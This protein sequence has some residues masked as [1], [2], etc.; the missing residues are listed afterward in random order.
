MASLALVLSTASACHLLAGTSCSSDADCVAPEL[1]ALDDVREHALEP[2]RRGDGADRARVEREPDV[3]VDEGVVL[4]AG[5]A[6]ERI[7]RTDAGLLARLEARAHDRDVRA[8]E[9][10]EATAD[11]LAGAT[12]AADHGGVERGAGIGF[13]AD[14]DPV[15]SARVG[16]LEDRGVSIET[17]LD[18]LGVDV[19]AAADDHVLDPVDD[20]QVAVLVDDPDVAGVQP[21]VPDHLGG[22]VRLA[23]IAAHHVGAA[24]HDLAALTGRLLFT[25]R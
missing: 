18:L 14:Q 5:E 15:P 16:G 23:E 7:R 4:E 22:L 1:V 11:V 20:S 25:V 19:L 2:L 8:A 13:A 6:E 9:D 10:R 24:D 12:A 17:L 3:G 21:S